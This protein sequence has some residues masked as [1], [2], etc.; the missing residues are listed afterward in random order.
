[1]INQ[2][3]TLIRRINVLLFS[4]LLDKKYDYDEHEKKI[5]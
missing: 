3:P 5:C 1:M 2:F 4:Y